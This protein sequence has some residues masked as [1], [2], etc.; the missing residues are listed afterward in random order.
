M[1]SALMISTALSVVPATRPHDP[2]VGF[3]LIENR[4]T[5]Q[6]GPFW[7]R[8]DCEFVG[9]GIRNHAILEMSDPYR[10]SPEMGL[11]LMT[12]EVVCLRRVK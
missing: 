10:T 5:Q 11:R 8:E 6:I 4:V 12:T 7:D 2:H 1:F 3:V 9:K